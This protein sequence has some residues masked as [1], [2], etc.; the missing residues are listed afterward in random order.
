MGEGL[1]EASSTYPVKINPST[2]QFKLVA[3]ENH[4]YMLSP[5]SVLLHAQLN[6]SALHF[7]FLQVSHLEK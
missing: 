4:A 2:P 7:Y 3:H 6:V 5:H 1:W